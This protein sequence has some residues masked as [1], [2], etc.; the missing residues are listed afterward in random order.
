TVVTLVLVYRLDFSMAL[1]HCCT[2]GFQGA[3]MRILAIIVGVGFTIAILRDAF[4]TIVLPRRVSRKFRLSR[5]FYTST[6]MLWSSLARKMRQGNRREYYLGYFGPL[7]LILLLMVWAAVLI[8]GF[9]L[10]QWGDGSAL[11]AP[12]KVVTFW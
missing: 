10:L 9:A 4:E 3:S 6:W 12:E 8:V 1:G 2:C 5:I 7:S 11:S